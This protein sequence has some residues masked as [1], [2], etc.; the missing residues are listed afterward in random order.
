MDTQLEVKSLAPELTPS[1]FSEAL[2]S[3]G[4][5]LNTGGKFFSFNYSATP[6]A[7]HLQFIREYFHFGA[8]ARAHI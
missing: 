7:L 2:A 6:M 5:P 8:T 3:R 1:L 4:T